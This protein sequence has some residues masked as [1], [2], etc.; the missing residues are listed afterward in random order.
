MLQDIRTLIQNNSN[1]TKSDKPQNPNNTY[2]GIGDIRSQLV[3]P[4]KTGSATQYEELEGFE[5]KSPLTI[6]GSEQITTDDITQSAFSS[7]W[8]SFKQGVDETQNSNYIAKQ[9][10]FQKIIDEN[11]YRKKELDKKLKV[12]SISKDEYDQALSDIGRINLEN[13]K[14]IDKIQE[15]IDSNKEEM[16]DEYVSK[17]YKIKEAAVQA[18][19]GDA[20]LWESIKYTM[21]STMGSSASLLG[22]QL[23]ATF[24]T[25]ALKK[26]S[27]R[28]AESLLG[29]GE[30][31]GGIATIAT[32]AGT[33]G[34]LYYG[35]DQETYAEEGGQLEQNRQD[36]FE[37]WQK[38]NPNT[39][40]AGLPKEQQ[41]DILREIRVQS[42]K[43]LDE[44]RDEQMKLLIP[45]AIEA[46]LFPGSKILQSFKLG[47]ELE[48]TIKGIT[49][50]NKY[51]RVGKVL[52]K[53][54]AGYLGEK[55][56]EGFQ[57]ATEKRQT[58]VALGL[59]NYKNQ[60]F[61]S[62][63]LTDSNDTIES[64]SYGPYG[65]LKG[66][67][68][69]AND[70][71]FQFAEQ[72]GGLL[73]IMMGGLGHGLSIAKDINTYKQTNKDLK[74][75]GIANI[76]DKYFRLNDQVYQKHFENDTI[77][78]L[79]EGI[80]N[81]KNTKDANGNPILTETQ[82]QDEIQ[83]I[84]N[85]FK[86]YTEVNRYVE[87]LTPEGKL[88]LLDS[89][90]QK[91]MKKILSKELF[92]TSMQ[93]VR[94]GEN[95]QKLEDVKNINNLIEHQEKIVKSLESTINNKTIKSIFNIEN[96]TKLAKKKLEDLQLTKSNIL[97][98]F[99]LKEEDLNNQFLTI[100]ESNKNKENLIKELNFYDTQEK[101]N[102]LLKIKNNDDLKKWFY[103]KIAQSEIKDEILNP[104]KPED[105]SKINNVPQDTK[106]SGFDALLPEVNLPEPQQFKARYKNEYE[107]LVE[108]LRSKNTPKE[109]HFHYER[110]NKFLNKVK[111]QIEANIAKFAE[112]PVGEYYKNTLK[113]INNEIEINKSKIEKYKAD[114]EEDK[115]NSTH[116]ILDA[117]TK[118]VKLFTGFLTEPE[119]KN[120][121]EMHQAEIY[122]EA[123]IKIED[124]DKAG[125]ETLPKDFEGKEI[126]NSKVKIKSGLVSNKLKGKGVYVYVNGNR[127]GGLLDPRRFTI[128]G[129]PFNPGNMKHLEALNPDFVAKN[130]Q[131]ILAPTDQGKA[132][133][134]TYKAMVDVFKILEEKGEFTNEE[135]RKYFFVDRTGSI[136]YTKDMASKPSLN[137]IANEADYAVEYSYTDSLTDEKNSKK[138]VPIF[139]F[140]NGSISQIFVRDENGN[141]REVNKDKQSDEFNTLTTLFNERKAE[142]EKGTRAKTSE[143]EAEKKKLTGQF[144]VL[145]NNP[146]AK[147]K[148]DILSAN[149][150]NVEVDVKD[151]SVVYNQLVNLHE[152]MSKKLKGNEDE[153][154]GTTLQDG[155]GNTYFISSEGVPGATISIG[156]SGRTEDKRSEA[157]KANKVKDTRKIGKLNVKI[158]LPN[159]AGK[160]TLFSKNELDG[161]GKGEL[162]IFLVEDEGETFFIRIDPFNDKV[163]KL[164]NTKDLLN[165]INKDIALYSKRKDTSGKTYAQNA[166]LKGLKLLNFK[167]RVD[168]ETSSKDFN[169]LNNLQMN[170]IPVRSD[171]KFTPKGVDKAASDNNK[172]QIQ[173]DKKT[174]SAEDIEIIESFISKINNASEEKLEVLYNTALNYAKENKA[175]KKY[176]DNIEEAYSNRL[177]T[178]KRQSS[179]NPTK[180]Q[181]QVN[182]NKVKAAAVQLEINRLDNQII[183]A[184]LRDASKEEIEEL[185]NKKEALQKELNNLALNG[186]DENGVWK[187]GEV[188]P[189]SNPID[190]EQAKSRL[191][192]ILPSWIST[193]FVDTISNNLGE[194]NI[195]WGKFINDVIYLS[196][197]AEKGTE[198]HEAFHA[199]FRTILTPSEYRSLLN[200]AKEKYSK[201]SEE[202]LIKLQSY[203][204]T[205]FSKQDLIDLYYEEKLADDFQKYAVNEDNKNIFKFIWDKIKN[206]IRFFYDNRSEID[207]IFHNIYN[208]V[209]KNA[210]PIM[211]V[212]RRSDNPAFKLIPKVTKFNTEENKFE[213][214]FLSQA[215][216]E[217][218]INTIALNTIKNNSAPEIEDIELQIA[219]ILNHYTVSN[220]A[221]EIRKVMEVDRERGLEIA[222]EIKEI[223]EAIKDRT[224]KKAIIETVKDRIA[225][226]NYV[227][228]E[229][230]E[231]TEDES[232]DDGYI[233]N[234]STFTIGGWGTLS[235]EMKQF[236]AF[237]EIA[238]DEFGF[239]NYFKDEEMKSSKFNMASNPFI[240]YTGVERIL[241]DVPKNKVF[242]R[243]IAYANK[244]E[245]AK[246]FKDNLIRAISDE[247]GQQVDENTS[248]DIL[249]NSNWYNK[250]VTAFTKNKDVQS[251]VLFDPTNKTFK[252]FKANQ[253]DEAIFQFDEWS[254]AFISLNRQ[255]PIHK[256][257][258]IAILDGIKKIFISRSLI[259]G[260]DDEG[261]IYNLSSTVNDVISSFK[262]LGIE[263]S[264]GY[265]RHSLI[266]NQ[267]EFINNKLAYSIDKNDQTQIE[268]FSNLLKEF[269]TFDEIKGM[270]VEDIDGL[271]ASI[272]TSN[273]PFKTSV[274]EDNNVIDTGAIGRLKD[275][276]SS[277]ALFDE[278]VTGSTFQNAKGDT[279]YDKILPSYLTTESA[280][281]R[282]SVRREFIQAVRDG[283]SDEDG[284][285]L[286][287]DV[288]EEEG[289]YMHDYLVKSFYQSIK[290]N[291]LIL[292]I[293]YEVNADGKTTNN[294]IY[295][296]EL[297]NLIFDN[298]K[299]NTLSGLRSVSFS[300][301]VDEE[302][303]EQFVL[304]QEGYK[305][306]NGQTFADLDPRSKTVMSMSLF[307]KGKS[308][309]TN[310]NNKLRVEKTM[311]GEGTKES[312]NRSFAPILFGVIEV[313]STQKTVLLPVNKFVDKDGKLNSL[314]KTHLFQHIK[315]E[316]ERINKVQ[317]E[318]NQGLPKGKVAPDVFVL[319]GYHTEETPGKG[320]APRGLEFFNFKYLNRINPELYKKLI[321]AAKK[322]E[323][324]N[325]FQTEI[326]TALSDFY[327]FQ[328]NRFLN[329]L[330]KRGVITQKTITENGVETTTYYNSSLPLDY[331][332]N[333]NE[334]NLAAV[335]DYFSN[336]YINSMNFNNL[337]HGDLATNY[338][339]H[340]DMV[341][342]NAKLIASGP[343]LGTD[344]T[345]VSVVKSV[346]AKD[347]GDFKLSESE[348][349]NDLENTDTTDAQNKN[350]LDWYQKKYLLGLGKSN[351]KIKELFSKM[352]RGIKLNWAES[353]YLINSNASLTP[354]KIVGA[355]TFFYDKT[356]TI[357]ILRANTSYVE[358]DKDRKAL[359]AIYD[360]I[361]EEL[362]GN[363]N[364]AV[365]AALYKETHKYWKPLPSNTYN[366]HLLNALEANSIDILIYDS[367]M[368][369][370]KPN[371]TEMPKAPE[372]HEDFILNGFDVSDTIFREQVNT[373][374]S[375]KTGID[376][377]QTMNLIWSEQD[378][379]TKVTIYGKNTTV[380]EIQ[381]AYVAL[382]GKRVVNS[383]NNIRKAIMEGD[384]P[385]YD[386]LLN[387]F[388][389]SLGAQ[390]ADPYI[391]EF[392]RKAEG[393][394]NT[395]KYNLNFPA[396]LTK[397]ENMWLAYVGKALKI[398]AP[399]HKFSLV[400]DHGVSVTFITENGKERIITDKEFLANPKKFKNNLESRRLKYS[401]LQDGS[402]LSEC[403]IPAQ[404]A[405]QFN[406][407]VGDTIPQ[408]LLK[409]LGVRIPTQDKQ[410]MVN[411]IVVDFLPAE[412]G[413]AVIL[414]LEIVKLS[415][416]D[417][418]IDSL[419]VRIFDWYN[420]KTKNKIGYFGQYLQE[421]TKSAAVAVAHDEYLAH[422]VKHDS[423]FKSKL[424]E[425]LST[426][427]KFNTLSKG[428]KGLSDE[429]FAMIAYNKE[430]S[431]EYIKAI[432]NDF[433]EKLLEA[434][435][436]TF[437]FDE[438]DN[439][440]QQYSDASTG[441]DEKT[442]KA[443]T[444]LLIA[445]AKKSR[446]DYEKE[447]KAPLEK[448]LKDLKDTKTQI[449]NEV[450]ESLGYSVNEKEFETKFGKQVRDNVDAFNDER[451]SDIQPLNK[452]EI[453]NLLL[454]MSMQLSHNQG[455]KTIANTPSTTKMFDEADNLLKANELE[456]EEE[457][458]GVASPYDKMVADENNTSGA[459]GIG[460][461]AVFNVMFQRLN[462]F[463]IK[464]RKG[465]D[466]ILGLDNF[467]SYNNTNGDRI[468]DNNSTI[469]T[470]H[471]DNAKD[472]KAGRYNISMNTEGIL[473]NNNGMGMNPTLNLFLSKQN[474]ISIFNRN[475]DL[476]KSELSSTNEKKRDIASIIEYSKQQ[477][478][479]SLTLNKDYKYDET[480]ELS[481]SNL[482]EAMKFAEGK[483][484]TMTP[485]QYAN[486]QIK[487]LD[488]MAK[489]KEYADFLR[490]FTDILGLIRGTK[491]TWNEAEQVFV[492]LKKL[493]I[494][495]FL[496][497]GADPYEYDSYDFKHVNGFEKDETS[498]P[499]DL[500]PIIKNDKLINT[501]LLVFNVINKYGEKFFISKTKTAEE[502][503]D[504][505]KNQMRD[506]YFDYDDNRSKFNRSLISYLNIKAFKFMNKVNLQIDN[507]F[508]NKTHKQLFSLLSKDEFANNELLKFLNPTTTDYTDNKRSIFEG[509]TLYKLEGNTRTKNNPDF[510]VL[511][512]DGFRQLANSNDVEARDFAKNLFNYLIVKDNLQFK[513]NSFVRQIEP[514]FLH[515]VS[516]SLDVVQDLLSNDV[517]EHTFKETFGVSKEELIRE[518]TEVY[519]RDS[520]NAFNLK[521]VVDFDV[522]K[523]MK[524]AVLTKLT[525]KE[526][527]SEMTAEEKSE[528]KDFID[529]STLE[530][531]A[532]LFFD[533]DEN[534]RGIA[535]ID[536]FKN[537]KFA[538][539]NEDQKSENSRL[540]KAN[541]SALLSIKGLFEYNEDTKLI[542]FPLV[543][544]RRYKVGDSTRKVY[545]ILKS[546]K[547][548][549][550]KDGK[551]K[552]ITLP[553]N[554]LNGTQ[555]NEG[556]S[557]E[558]AEI[559]TV[560]SYE[561][562]PY[563]FSPKEWND[564]IN[565]SKL[566]AKEESQP[567][568]QGDEIN[569]ANKL[570][571]SE[572]ISILDIKTKSGKTIADLGFDQEDWDNFSEEKQNKIIDCN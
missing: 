440:I 114:A 523:K 155:D 36:L 98:E 57:Y 193:Q 187:I 97:N 233:F 145:V 70:P 249:K 286:L 183:D 176:L 103:D 113:T 572:K 513:N 459:K 490:N 464:L 59:H 41:E 124:Y 199:V 50:Y 166:K 83:N 461:A 229:D 44:M 256:D 493:G 84:N 366:H 109:I 107:K 566:L 285:K 17:L 156:I 563:A 531:N 134:D 24:T 95:I 447:I 469:L 117:A 420:N 383:L 571:K 516:K 483:P 312:R 547:T 495:I 237:S 287:K 385:K 147:S 569:T 79:Y 336:D 92:H 151:A 507:L 39:N 346:K 355:D 100:E 480:V 69:Y 181:N 448:M 123:I 401:K 512:M 463:N 315:Q 276:A 140:K 328:F 68:R 223:N 423:D 341:K 357:T 240:V 168:E 12:G 309:L 365:I 35:R 25:G 564:F 318:I 417:F 138:G 159:N 81:L 474:I 555:I 485:E 144:F 291:P 482:I 169:G 282:D 179:T 201:P 370:I 454:E 517:T 313:K 272:N 433:E 562:A 4:L 373:D 515:K 514:H 356:S 277:N 232:N 418:D 191:K 204:N 481:V 228:N 222:K 96:R 173:Q 376:P 378:R 115:T 347:R 470:V 54:Y 13:Q 399:M 89:P 369:Q 546:Y 379:N 108:D 451:F 153:V 283:I 334:L 171:I 157:D 308:R 21:P 257:S 208:G 453:D 211:G 443:V 275:I 99:N 344:K 556:V 302:G 263:L 388:A 457:T 519:M 8:N 37:M 200:R 40:F 207:T 294:I 116:K 296:N 332:F 408:H 16:E 218:I 253:K 349:I 543:F 322:G 262:K 351:P 234:Q 311:N 529:R 494:E 300:E 488:V 141:I 548:K 220:F 342:R 462:K 243:F 90:E 15:D 198:Y 75:S 444:K 137:T 175:S 260:K 165:A 221:D 189:T 77:H 106:P 560:G 132:V 361:E 248:L 397:F 550:T 532:P 395:P 466:S 10:A 396:T 521:S 415:G 28:V 411:L 135:V 150:P 242:Q 203:Y 78:Y 484:T 362:F 445:I 468:N 542:K 402:Y 403:K 364:K 235:K 58:D 130:A 160:I 324:I 479:D 125:E 22:S 503:K 128:D 409:M 428:I 374:G 55:F 167:V 539:G 5:S 456:V 524:D 426:N 337:L 23:A 152:E 306:S 192:K 6:Q 122:N 489:Q 358:T 434:Q 353:Q 419:F 473:L 267:I 530:E 102:K 2:K 182:D 478:L 393:L 307:A 49:D 452:G 18:K 500:L 467:S 227:D 552:Y 506:G 360:K 154:K 76:D 304:E 20:G 161:I 47:R 279:V 505:V 511:L 164:N 498:Y 535:S 273:N 442:E 26:L 522:A 1:N 202:D 194:N 536:I 178:L 129:K 527:V 386:K 11:A 557:A 565:T 330:V 501:N 219:N 406:L 321:D 245:H 381:D 391:Q 217:R 101:Y 162:N 329:L 288:L 158:E 477:I 133:Q 60:G 405:E 554:N 412:Y 323:D 177:N 372:S 43:G 446:V 66:E 427:V 471:T 264:E 377:T 533:R 146:T 375:K 170:A 85:A 476:K 568:Q 185:E 186:S 244:T 180:V 475:L 487:T 88:G 325:K 209:Y 299:T 350:T 9:D 371:V 326:E 254:K 439:Y 149:T 380:G 430:L 212:I 86:K 270:D 561:I 139:K 348:D 210:E 509:L 508:N 340:N 335:H 297:S 310:N 525:S 188:T 214:G 216:S 458:L 510:V 142:I 492:S 274:D 258:N 269:N 553:A 320:K 265:I 255:N 450:L 230:R 62:N 504:V 382:L 496:K 121:N 94:D 410:S 111:K 206:L 339:N 127:I 105:T 51:T 72:S 136:K 231:N 246:G 317:N 126:T 303:D 368:K 238:V 74:E 29:P 333:N 424:R 32:I 148:H 172:K 271:I 435:R 93:L 261:N 338:K 316:Y 384:K 345:T 87:D 120:L 27:T 224:T 544:Y 343:S 567:S 38:N 80:R 438:D 281:W 213:T 266:A 314:G 416:A 290:N 327:D 131:G 239:N 392:F 241:T 436:E 110:I 432:K 400:S 414:P 363:N 190:I 425:A 491:K 45:D 112:T 31:S 197:F 268:Y 65:T 398:K 174:A 252:A 42:R 518:F 305:G 486:I 528:A 354:R 278:S 367:A 119:L 404:F 394:S 499:F 540:V 497:K 502:I 61:I 52:G 289:N 104:E 298:I 64:I 292:G 422:A 48:Q 195:A 359:D 56:E 34:E 455:N 118:F 67:G 215:Q 33:L 226:F 143:T 551:T 413:N 352:R 91:L 259:S 549:V 247:L 319:E 293:E 534:G 441:F 205:K 538:K 301:A 250:F 196:K 82:A 73:G 53:A 389:K 465:F 3:H 71:Q 541:I 407:K 163:E 251:V 19:G 472:P 7:A 421:S 280:K 520:T 449:S 460:P 431:N 284:W 570:Q 295:N 236:I 46:T 526:E 63:L 559:S 429:I 558:Y 387:E 225:L 30:V 390:N 14:Q 545:Y 537:T 184:E 437:E 331:Q